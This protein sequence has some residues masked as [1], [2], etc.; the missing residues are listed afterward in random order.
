MVEITRTG[1]SGRMRKIGVVWVWSDSEVRLSRSARR[2]E[3]VECMR[4]RVTVR[5][6]MILINPL[7]TFQE[8]Q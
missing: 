6:K 2:R 1:C 3:V 7:S 4:T 8:A 5:S